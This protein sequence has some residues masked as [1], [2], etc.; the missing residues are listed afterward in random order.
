MTQ[1]MHSHN[2]S[3]IPTGE[4]TSIFG[5]FIVFILSWIGLVLLLVREL[6][7][8]VVH[9]VYNASDSAP[10]GL[11]LVEPASQLRVGDLV[12][13]RLP[14]NVAALA[15]QRGYLPFGVPVIKP[16]A[17]LAPQH[18]CVDDSGVH[19]DGESLASTLAADAMGRTL[20][21]WHGCRQL[22][23]TELFLLSMH[24]SS[25]D[26]RYFG[27]LDSAQVIGRARPLLNRRSS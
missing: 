10:R 22:V 21:P 20:S 26:S 11:Y 23:D 8:P 6:S 16:V 24:P 17:A 14:R 1:H 25:F 7:A 18:V 4:P 2:A 27:P 13:V 12:V 5:Q 15:A 9:I 19:V 3:P